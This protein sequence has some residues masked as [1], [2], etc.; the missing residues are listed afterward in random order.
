[1]ETRD[2]QESASSSGLKPGTPFNAREVRDDLPFYELPD[3]QKSEVVSFSQLGQEVWDT[4][5]KTRLHFQ[6]LES[7]IRNPPVY[8]I[9]SVFEKLTWV[10]IRKLDQK[11]N[12]P[13]EF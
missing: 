6:L 2:T 10:F 7:Q 11:N 9:C 12:I 1:M 8:G 4:H 3:T 13:S 5:L